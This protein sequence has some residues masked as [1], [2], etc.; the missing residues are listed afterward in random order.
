MFKVLNLLI[1]L[2]VLFAP[3]RAL[4]AYDEWG[5][6]PLTVLISTS[7][8]TQIA[9]KIRNYSRSRGV[10]IVTFFADPSE[11]VRDIS[12]G[13]RADYVI[14]DNPYWIEQLRQQGLIE[15]NSRKVLFEPSLKMYCNRLLSGSKEWGDGV[16]LKKYLA[17]AGNKI[18]VCDPDK[19]ALGGYVEKLLAKVGVDVQKSSKVII[20]SSASAAHKLV[21]EEE[22]VCTIDYDFVNIASLKNVFVAEIS[23]A[24]DVKVEFT[25]AVVA[26]ENM[27]AARDFDKY[28]RE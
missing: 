7:V 3:L 15:Y 5:G 19:C 11:L 9:E 27:D 13:G 20:M 12:E 18:A 1:C 22:S 14:S 17:V 10:R 26:G 2:M 24:K 16:D 4:S 23:N 6:D 21:E 28:I 8:K 25:S